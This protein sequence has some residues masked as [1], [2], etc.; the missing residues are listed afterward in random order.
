MKI[1]VDNQTIQKWK[2]DIR[3]GKLRFI[4][5]QGIFLWGLPM[6]ILVYF[7]RVGLKLEFLYDFIIVGVFGGIIFGLIM[8]LWV[9][10]N[11][12]FVTKQKGLKKKINFF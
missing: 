10:K 1:D 4:L 12:K 8:W 5:K 3:K 7:I 11:L 6:S 9:K 2:E